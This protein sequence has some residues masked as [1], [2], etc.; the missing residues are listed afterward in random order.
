MLARELPRSP[1]MA[2]LLTLLAAGAAAPPTK[3]F[4]MCALYVNETRSEFS[5]G[6]VAPSGRVTT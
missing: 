5:Y 1:T 6:L 2:A 4:S 3:N